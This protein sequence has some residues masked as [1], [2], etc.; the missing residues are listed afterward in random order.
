MIILKNYNLNESM[1][2][3]FV[4]KILTFIFLICIW[5]PNND[6]YNPVNLF[7]KKF[8]HDGILVM[9]F[10]RLLAKHELHKE[11]KTPRLRENSINT[12]INK[13]MKNNTD[14]ISTY[15]NI[16]KAI[17]NDLDAYKKGY[18]SRQSK[19][20][21]FSKLECYCEKKVFD[22]IDYVYEIADNYRNNARFYKRKLFSK[23]IFPLYFFGL[24]PFLGLIMPL[25]FNESSPIAKLRGSD[26]DTGSCTKRE[27]HKCDQL[28]EAII[29][30]ST[31]ETLVVLNKILLFALIII[32][33]IVNTYILIKFIKYEKLK[34]G[35]SKMSVKEYCRLC[36]DVLM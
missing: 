23:C 26:H 8:R 15:G 29:T 18:K 34:A 24:L 21:G 2:F 4:L 19:K 6:I 9:Y 22:K 32:V 35:K 7:E 10:N 27:E 25:L 30:K 14:D 33:L 5:N 12:G 28:T 16:K 17:L 11:L 31:W 13:K 3:F 1:K 36:K 20:K